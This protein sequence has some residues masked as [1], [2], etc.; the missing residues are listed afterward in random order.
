MLLNLTIENVAL[1]EKADVNFENGFHILTGETGAGKSILIGSLNI[2]LGERIGHDIIRTGEN[3]AYVEGLFYPSNNVIEILKKEEITVEDDGSL[4]LSRRMFKDGKNICKAGDKTVSVSKLR[5][6]GRN[7]I[8]IHGQHD[9]QALL[10]VGTHVDFLDAL[11][12]QEEKA[13]FLEYASVFKTLQEQKKRLEALDIDETEKLR[14][15]DILTYEINEIKSAS[16]TIGE[17]EELKRERNLAKN[18]EDIHKNSALMLDLLYENAEGVCVYNL[19]SDAQRA[20]DA[21]LALGCGVENVSE[22]ISEILYKVEDIIGTIRNENDRSF[23]SDISVDEIEERLDLIYRLKRKY[24]NTE[25]EILEYCEKAETELLSIKS[26]DEEK[27][28]LIRSIATLNTQAEAL[29]NQIHTIRVTVAKKIESEIER[30]LSELNMDGAT[31]RVSF[32]TTD[33]TKNGCDKIEFLLSANK[34]EP[35]KPLAKIVSGG[36]LSRIMLALKKV[37]SKGD[38]T[39]TLI[40]DEIDTGIS[41]RVA[42]RVGDKLFEISKVKQVIC[43]TH[44][45]QIAALSKCHFKIYKEEISGKTKTAIKKLTND[46][47]VNEIAFMI[48]GDNVTETTLAQAKEMTDKID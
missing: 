14:K 42:S 47:K 45:P 44:L 3:Y 17:E 25:E 48:G 2:L 35:P 10:D 6:I 32:E 9:N 27:E 23:S 30:E 1:I 34:G 43:V 39:E 26:S 37:L 28:N 38:V 22:T 13:S 11:V 20:T 16:L 41:G 15:I 19:L 12:P 7:L 40:F 46:E 36:E 33:L 24:G 5:E 21:L 18:R 4:I 29:A 8:N 31:F